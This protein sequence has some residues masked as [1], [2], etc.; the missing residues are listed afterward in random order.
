MRIKSKFNK[1]LILMKISFCLCTFFIR[2]KLLL[3]KLSFTRDHATP[4]V[5]LSLVLPMSL[6][7]HYTRWSSVTAPVLLMGCY[8][9]PVVTWWSVTSPTD[10][11]ERFLLS[12]VFYLAF[13]PAFFKASLGPVFQPQSLQGFMLIFET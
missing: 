11:R 6:V 7:W 12:G 2:Q 1:R 5:T 4:V 10:L 3:E 9:M 8:G 13:L